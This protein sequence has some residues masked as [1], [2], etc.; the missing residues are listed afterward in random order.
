[1]TAAQLELAQQSVLTG[2]ATSW[3]TTPPMEISNSGPS[4]TYS[5]SPARSELSLPVIAPRPQHAPAGMT[6]DMWQDHVNAS[7]CQVS[8]NKV[9][10]FSVTLGTQDLGVPTVAVAGLDLGT[11]QQMH[12]DLEMLFDPSFTGINA[13]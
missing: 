9:Q 4:S 3:T 5:G 11:D 13:F 6:F 2:D 10:G 1:M 8:E 12:T 7:V